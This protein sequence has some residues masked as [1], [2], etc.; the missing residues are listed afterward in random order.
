MWADIFLL[1]GVAL[2][3]PRKMSVLVRWETPRCARS[4]I[5]ATSGASVTCNQVNKKS[6]CCDNLRA[7]G[8]RCRRSSCCLTTTWPSSTPSWWASGPSST[9]SCG[10]ATPPCWPT[11]GE[12]CSTVRRRNSPGRS[13]W[14]VKIL[15][16]YARNGSIHTFYIHYSKSCSL[17]CQIGTFRGNLIPK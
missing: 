7:A 10:S 9:W 11:G 1:S 12:S 3:F 4:V 15:K 16:L 6:L 5:L 14:Q 2:M 13:I 17:W 8:A